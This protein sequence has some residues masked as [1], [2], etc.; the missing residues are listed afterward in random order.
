MLQAFE[1]VAKG[2]AKYPE[3]ERETT[4]LRSAVR[5]RDARHCCQAD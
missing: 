3:A 4:P 2:A 1:G 5:E